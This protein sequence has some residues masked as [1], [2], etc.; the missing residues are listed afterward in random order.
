MGKEEI[1]QKIYKLIED[2]EDE[3]ALQMLYDDAVDYKTSVHTDEDDL[4]EGQWEQIEK[5]RAEIKKGE[6]HTYDEVKKHF[7]KWLTK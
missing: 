1:K 6:F 5:A 3:T 7:A 4:T 2:M